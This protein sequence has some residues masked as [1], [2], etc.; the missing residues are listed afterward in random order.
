MIC[1]PDIE[2]KDDFAAGKHW[3]FSFVDNATSDMVPDKQYAVLDDL[4]YP[5]ID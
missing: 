3:K 5:E 2:A 1:K 4:N